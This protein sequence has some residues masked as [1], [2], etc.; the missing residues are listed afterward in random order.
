V[1]IEEEEQITVIETRPSKCKK[2]FTSVH[3]K[4][5]TQFLSTQY[6]RFRNKKIVDSSGLLD[7]LVHETLVELVPQAVVDK[8]GLLLVRLGPAAV[9]EDDIVVPAALDAHVRLGGVRV[10]LL[11]QRVAGQ[12]VLHADSLLLL[13]ALGFLQ[14]KL[15]ALKSVLQIRIRR[16]HMFLSLLD[17]NPSIIKQK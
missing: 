1:K 12:D 16:I 8:G 13:S 3:T 11:E 5:R 6:T 14:L 9:L 7:V 2:A 17:P 4:Y 10:L 15:G